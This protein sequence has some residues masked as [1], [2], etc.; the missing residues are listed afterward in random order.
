[1]TKYAE[2][3]N[4]VKKVQAHHHT[5]TCRFNTPWAPLNKT[6]MIRSDEKIDETI[7]NQSKKRIQKVPSCMVA[8]SDLS[9]V[10]LLTLECGVTAEQF[11]NALGCLEKKVSILYKR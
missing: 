3:S 1:M 5:A 6:R 8:I 10:T 4:L 11:D 9:D 7:V 2:M